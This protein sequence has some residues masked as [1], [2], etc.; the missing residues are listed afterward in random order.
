MDNLSLPEPLQHTAERDGMKFYIKY[1][2]MREFQKKCFTIILVP[3]YKEAHLEMD[4]NSKSDRVEWGHARYQSLYRCDQ[5][6]EIIAQWVA[7]SGS[8]VADLV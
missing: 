6:Y 2:F 4:V 3:W 8:V 1:N 5:A 7:A